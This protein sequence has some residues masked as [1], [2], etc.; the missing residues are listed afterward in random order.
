MNHTLT[1]QTAFV[2]KP[3][4]ELFCG[5]EIYVGGDLPVYVLFFTT[6]DFKHGHVATVT[7]RVHPF[8]E[9]N[10]MSELVVGTHQRLNTNCRS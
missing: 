6:A 3:L 5:V 8:A 2:V 1:R 4:W 7:Q 9:A 10:W